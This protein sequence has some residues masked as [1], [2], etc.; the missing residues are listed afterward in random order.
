MAKELTIGI[1]QDTYTKAKQ[2]EHAL[3]QGDTVTKTLT[4]WP[5]I[6]LDSLWAS[7][8]YNNPLRE[9]ERHHV[10]ITDNLRRGLN[11]AAFARYIDLVEGQE[12]E[13]AQ[14]I[15]NQHRMNG[16]VTTSNQLP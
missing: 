9:P 10:Q 3:Q 13:L 7:R 5:I 15:L 2:L 12:V 1:T 11:R 4:R 14:D 6:R 16:R 8:P